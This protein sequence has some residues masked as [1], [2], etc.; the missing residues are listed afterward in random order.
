MSRWRI[1]DA[2]YKFAD[3]KDMCDAIGREILIERASPHP[4]LEE[5]DRLYRDRIVCRA[6]MNRDE[7]QIMRR[8]D[9]HCME[10]GI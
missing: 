8:V 2:V 7:F 5:L 3:T 4:D 1:M 10:G 9:E 6:R